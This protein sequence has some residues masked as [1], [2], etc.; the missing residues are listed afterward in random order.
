[1]I[2]CLT[3]IHKNDQMINEV[4]IL[5]CLPPSSMRHCTHD[6]QQQTEID[7]FKIDL[8]LGETTNVGRHVF[9]LIRVRHTM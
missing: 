3:H 9:L 7:S 6:I 8:G 1:M 4:F 5:M 2:V